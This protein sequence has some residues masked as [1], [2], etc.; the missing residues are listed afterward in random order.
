MGLLLLLINRL[1]GLQKMERVR[2]KERKQWARSLFSGLLKIV[3]HPV[4]KKEENKKRMEYES[5]KK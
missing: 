1:R 5:D 4:D 3:G 2:R